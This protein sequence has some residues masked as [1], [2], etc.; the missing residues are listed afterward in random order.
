[1]DIAQSKAALEGQT[2]AYNELKTNFYMMNS[3][4]DVKGINGL[5]MSNSGPM[6]SIPK[7]VMPSTYYKP[8]PSRG[9]LNLMPSA[10]MAM[11]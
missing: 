11:T 1:M 2:R 4:S 9:T 6:I 3:N 5:S 8:P 7:V 10:S